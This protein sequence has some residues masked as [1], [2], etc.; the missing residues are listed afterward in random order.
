MPFNVRK[1]EDSLWD[2]SKED[3]EIPDDLI[4]RSI[5]VNVEL[6]EL[7]REERKKEK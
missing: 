7:I 4:I 6:I 1:F 2:F 3:V 5:P